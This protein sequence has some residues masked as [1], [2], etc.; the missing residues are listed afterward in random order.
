MRSLSGEYRRCTN[1]TSG[2]DISPLSGLIKLNFLSLSQSKLLSIEP[3]SE[4]YNMETLNISGTVLSNLNFLKKMNNLQHL[5]LSNT[6]INSLDGAESII[7][8]RYISIRGT[9]LRDIRPIAQ[10]PNLETIHCDNSHISMVSDLNKWRTKFGYRTVS[11]GGGGPTRWKK[12][13]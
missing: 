4:L 12:N 3:I 9:K 8:L 10:L 13:I 5:N 7:L 11:Y 1:S 6:K 2:I